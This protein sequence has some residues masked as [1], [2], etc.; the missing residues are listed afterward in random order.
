M[1]Q[2]A[3]SINLVS[4]RPISLICFCPTLKKML[5]HNAKLHL[6][7]REASN[8][9]YIANYV[10]TSFIYSHPLLLRVF[11]LSILEAKEK[12]HL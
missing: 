3:Q 11:L 7:M 8:F 1:K 4:D 12:T 2:L 9:I 5:F 6:I 10:N